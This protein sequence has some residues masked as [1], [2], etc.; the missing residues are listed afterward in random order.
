MKQTGRTSIWIL[1][2]S[3]LLMAGPLAAEKRTYRS[4]QPVHDV[5]SSFLDSLE[6]NNIRFA[7]QKTYN[8]KTDGRLGFVLVLQPG[9][10]LMDVRFMSESKNATLVQVQTH[11]QSD[12]RLAHKMLAEDLKMAEVGVKEIDDSLPAGWPSL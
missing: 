4:A 5:I 9:K 10:R 11:S 7:I 2:I 8:E 1:C 3:A 12:G 6:K